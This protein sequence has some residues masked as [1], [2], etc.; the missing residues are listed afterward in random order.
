MNIK[1]QWYIKLGEFCCVQFFLQPGI[2]NIRRG[3]P[4]AMCLL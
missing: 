3:H 1:I 2:H 4:S